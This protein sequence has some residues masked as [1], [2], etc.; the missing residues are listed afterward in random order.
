MNWSKTLIG[1]VVGGI[2]LFIANFVLHGLI[3]GNT[4]MKYPEVF[5]QEENA[6]NY[7]WFTVVCLVL[8]ILAA[9]LFAKTRESWADGLKGGVVAGM[10]AGA[11]VGAT[12]FFDSLVIL[13]F[14]YYLA[15]CHFG[16]DVIAFALAGAGIALVVK[17]S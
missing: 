14:P 16:S 13:G 6:A 9:I 3:L 2:S 7:V 4:Y 12:N 8:G 15:W 5:D 1:G 17:K 11:L 10:W